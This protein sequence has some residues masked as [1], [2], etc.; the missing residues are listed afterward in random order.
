MS[1]PVITFSRQ[2][3]SPTLQHV[4]AMHLPEGKDDIRQICEQHDINDVLTKSH[5]RLTSKQ[6]DFIKRLLNDILDI[7]AG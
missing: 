3:N 7:R 4:F 6:P 5:S 1:T 2:D